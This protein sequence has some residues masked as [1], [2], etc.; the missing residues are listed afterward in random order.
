MD[1]T[2]FKE[3]IDTYNNKESNDN[4]SSG[5]QYKN[6]NLKF[7]FS[8]LSKGSKV[9]GIIMSPLDANGE[10]QDFAQT[11]D[12]YKFGKDYIQKTIPNDKIL[13]EIKN[14]ED[15]MSKYR[16]SNNYD[17]SY[18]TV[19][20]L[21][22][23]LFSQKNDIPNIIFLNI[24]Y[25]SRIRQVFGQLYK[26]FEKY[27]NSIY[28]LVLEFDLL[29]SG[30]INISVVGKIESQTIYKKY[31]GDDIN[32]VRKSVYR[33]LYKEKSL[34]GQDILQITS[35]WISL[36]M[37]TEGKDFDLSKLSKN[38]NTTNGVINNK[39]EKDDDFFNIDKN[40]TDQ[41]NSTDDDDFFNI[42]K[43]KT[44]DIPF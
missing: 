8:T 7:V 21:Y 4:K 2:K 31:Y 24:R 35:K 25:Y 30:E 3:K 12:Y 32:E 9:K 18:G 27:G 44:D 36:I 6:L 5:G 37:K 34:S 29:Q 14:I 41:D 11:K 40:K 42:D 26:L 43:N 16:N 33:M 19:E 10:E 15:F 23:P 1:L 38:K 17:I 20:N 22:I 39:I 28:D 13:N